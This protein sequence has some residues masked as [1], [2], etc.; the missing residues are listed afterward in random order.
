MRRIIPP[1]LIG[2]VAVGVAELALSLL[3]YAEAGFLR[4]LTVLLAV[5]LGSLAVGLGTAPGR[6][7]GGWSVEAAGAL[8]WRW[9]AA[10]AALGIASVV[11]AGWSFLG[12]LGGS[13]TQR[14]L[15]VV[16]LAALPM[17]V[18]GGVLGGLIARSPHRRI[19]A[20]A[21]AGGAMGATLLGTVVLTRLLPTSVLLGATVL[22]SAAALIDGS[23]DRLEWP[24]S[25]DETDDDSIVSIDRLAPD[26][27]I[28]IA[29]LAPTPLPVAATAERVIPVE[30]LA[31][32]PD[33]V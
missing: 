29:S 18:V 8:R 3:L 13:V 25:A 23:I 7:E 30:L 32:D 16:T 19:D 26:G 1:I 9:L 21:A 10:V 11:A 6:G 28:P 12:G 5:Q 33:P 20:W 27:V 15:A 14:A 31:P 4:A 24:G 17:L 22:T 2:A